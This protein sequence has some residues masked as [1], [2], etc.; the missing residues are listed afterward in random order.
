MITIPYDF[1]DSIV[2]GVNVNINEFSYQ[3]G[4]YKKTEKGLEYFCGCFLIQRMYL[5]TGKSNLK[6]ELNH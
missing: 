4:L 3:G 2:Y 6:F 1:D 5:L